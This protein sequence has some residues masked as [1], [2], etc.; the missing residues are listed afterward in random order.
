MNFVLL[1]GVIV[2]HYSPLSVVNNRLVCQN[3][4]QKI[5]QQGEFLFTYV[6]CFRANRGVIEREVHPRISEGSHI[7]SLMQLPIKGN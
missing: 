2:H 3:S 4:K 1:T 6:I 5:P 7:I